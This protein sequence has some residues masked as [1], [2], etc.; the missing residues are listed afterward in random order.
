M[1]VQNHTHTPERS[2]QQRMDALRNANEIR[3]YR[4]NLK[5]DIKAQRISVVDLLIDPP[6]EVETMKIFDLLLSIPQMGRVKVNK[7]LMT[8][9]ISPS[10]TVDGMTD[11]Q[12][13]EMVVMMRRRS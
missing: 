5:R 3:S 13:A 4:A 10:K 7:L 12:R 11:R 1:L 8:C 2:L 6:V 9:R